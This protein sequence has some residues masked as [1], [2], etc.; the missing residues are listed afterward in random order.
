MRTAAGCCAAV[1]WRARL[2]QHI[3]LDQARQ[4]KDYRAPESGNRLHARIFRPRPR[5][6]TLSERLCASASLLAATVL[7][8]FSRYMTLAL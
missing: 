5:S 8:P 7:D 4:P 6:S 2:L 3:L 1:A